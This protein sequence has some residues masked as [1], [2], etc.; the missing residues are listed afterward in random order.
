M[1]ATKS[2]STQKGTR[3]YDFT[4]VYEILVL[5]IV[6]PALVHGITSLKDLPIA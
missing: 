4:W 3:D 2:S 5:I 6:T 1:N